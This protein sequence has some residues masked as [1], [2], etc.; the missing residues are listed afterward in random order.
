M[1]HYIKIIIQHLLCGLFF[2][3]AAFACSVIVFGVSPGSD[4]MVMLFTSPLS[5]AVIALVSW[6]LLTSLGRSVQIWK[7]IV[8]GVLAGSVS[9][10]FAWYLSILFAYFRNAVSSLGETTVGPVDGIGASLVMTLFSLGV[11]GWVTIPVGA[12]TGAFLTALSKR[13]LAAD[14]LK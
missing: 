11:F 13:F 8:V 2:F 6:A 14:R 12:L 5:A 1:N 4:W 3:V 7:G 10:F 9:H